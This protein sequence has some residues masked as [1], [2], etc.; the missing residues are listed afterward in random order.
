MSDFTDTPAGGCD[1]EGFPIPA[2]PQPDAAATRAAML[3]IY[4]PKTRKKREK[5]LLA[6]DPEKP[7]RPPIPRQ[8]P[9]DKTENRDILLLL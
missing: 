3:E 1:R 9:F 5:Q 8:G 6:N 7:K 4:P 2:A